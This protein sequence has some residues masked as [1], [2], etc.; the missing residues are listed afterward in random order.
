MK[1]SLIVLFAL[2][3]LVVT[4]SACREDYV[5]DATFRNWCGDNLCSWKTEAG[6]IEKA[7]TWSDADPGV[8]FVDSPTRI[9]TPLIAGLPCIEFTSMASIDEDASISLSLDLNDDGV[10]DYSYPLSTANWSAAKVQILAPA[11]RAGTRIILEKKGRGNAVLAAVRVKSG[12]SCDG[13]VATATVRAESLRT[14]ETCTKD[15]ECASGICCGL[16]C[17]SCCPK[18]TPS[19]KGAEC[20]T[21][22]ADPEQTCTKGREDLKIG[23]AFLC[24]PGKGIGKTGTPCLSHSDC[25]SGVCQNLRETQVCSSIWSSSSSGS[26]GGGDNDN[27]QSGG[28][29]CP[30]RLIGTAE[31]QVGFITATTCN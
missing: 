27:C 4:T 23:V 31:C 8:R 7:P 15:S 20:E 2:A 25:E 5:A 1:R 18:G 11:S 29:L 26:S 24:D 10:V 3:A 19:C 6:R 14:N 22:C 21:A 9:S 13:A 30:D 12:G 17:S 16:R 28:E